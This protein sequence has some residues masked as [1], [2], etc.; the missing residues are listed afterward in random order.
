MRK[1]FK[2]QNRKT[3]RKN[4]KNRKTF[5]KN[6][7]TGGEKDVGTVLGELAAVVYGGFTLAAAL[8][9]WPV[10]VLYIAS[11][12]VSGFAAWGV[13][14]GVVFMS[15]KCNISS[16]EIIKD[17]SNELN[18]YCDNGFNRCNNKYKMNQIYFNATI[19]IHEY[20][21]KFTNP[22]AMN[23]GTCSSFKE[24]LDK[25]Y[26]YFLRKNGNIKEKSKEDFLNFLY[27]E[28]KLIKHMSTITGTWTNAFSKIGTV[29][30]NVTHSVAQGFRRVTGRTQY[31]D[32]KKADFE[33]KLTNEQ[34]DQLKIL[35]KYI[36]DP[37]NSDNIK[38]LTEETRTEFENFLGGNDTKYP[39]SENIYLM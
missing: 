38:R 32:E 3:F 35:E 7:K 25:L 17:L 21:K 19:F 23:T 6:R 13:K 15:D 5:R 27:C 34:K 28:G 1:T 18:K 36:T 12:V 2:R 11:G 4:R 20:H 16:P 37:N 33:N 31:A 8:A 39:G 29:A 24:I 9:I 26:N 30:R 14:N 22:V 10:S